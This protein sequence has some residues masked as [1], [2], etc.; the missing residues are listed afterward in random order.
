[1]G[2]P[3]RNTIVSIVSRSLLVL[4]SGIGGALLGALYVRLFVPRT[5]MGWDQLADALGGFMLGGLL[6][7]ALGAV[8][9]VRFEPRSRWL[10]TALA[11]AVAMASVVVLRLMAGGQS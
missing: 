4:F 9:A 2:R 11:V 1:M 5:G 10:A 3:W 8:G 7:L 6:G